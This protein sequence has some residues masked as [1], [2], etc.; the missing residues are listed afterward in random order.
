MPSTDR[1]QL[2]P[3]RF[4]GGAASALAVGGVLLSVQ[5]VVGAWANHGL[6]AVT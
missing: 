3:V 5:T 2:H 4:L 6:L 1:S